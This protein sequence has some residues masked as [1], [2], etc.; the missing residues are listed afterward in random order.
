MILDHVNINQTQIYV[1]ASDSSKELTFIGNKPTL[2]QHP[3]LLLCQAH[4]PP[5]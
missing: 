1:I 3:S 4:F 2:L 5:P